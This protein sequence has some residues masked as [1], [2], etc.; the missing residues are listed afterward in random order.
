MQLPE[1]EAADEELMLVP[2]FRPLDDPGIWNLA[3]YARDLGVREI[4]REMK[5]AF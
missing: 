5:E 3:R 1:R 2:A 4:P